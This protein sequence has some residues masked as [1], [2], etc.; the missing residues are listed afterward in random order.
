MSK[1]EATVVF[2]CSAGSKGPK[3]EQNQHQR[4]TMAEIEN[5]SAAIVGPD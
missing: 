1:H 4:F 2:Y 3:I 5:L